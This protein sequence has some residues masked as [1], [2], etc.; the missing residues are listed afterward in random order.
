MKILALDPGDAWTGIAIS[1]AAGMFARPLTTVASPELIA[2]LTA[3][4]KQEPISRVVVGHP[5]T[6]RGNVSEQTKKIEQLFQELKKSF[7]TIDWILW[8]E[9]LSSQR[10]DAMKKNISKED[11]L[12]SHA[13]AAAFILSSYLDYLSFQRSTD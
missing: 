8:D 2:A 6:M 3:L 11:K 12:Q 4:F 5:K 9:R 1:D 13:R 10:A 7:P